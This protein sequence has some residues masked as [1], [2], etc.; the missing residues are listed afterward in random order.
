MKIF[1]TVFQLLGDLP[2]EA[3]KQKEILMNQNKKKNHSKSTTYKKVCFLGDF[4]SLSGGF[5][6]CERRMKK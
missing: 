6:S 3:T 4:L 5:T 1:E 2:Y